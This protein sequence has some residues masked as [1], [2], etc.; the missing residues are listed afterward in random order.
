MD[1]I[2]KHQTSLNRF[3]EFLPDHM[4][5]SE[6]NV[7]GFLY[8]KMRSNYIML[9]TWVCLTHMDLYRFALPDFNTGQISDFQRA[10]PYEFLVRCQSQVVAYACSLA[11]FWMYAGEMIGTR[12]RSS[13]S[14]G[15]LTIDW[16][17]GAGAVDVVTVLLTAR[18]YPSLYRK[19]RDGS[20][21]QLCKAKDV[22]DDMLSSMISSMIS[23]LDMVKPLVPRIESY[24]RVTTLLL[25]CCLSLLTCPI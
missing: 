12:A 14:K 25:A 15:L 11:Q 21:A 20:S 23:V 8:D 1:I 13:I 4:K 6:Q 2:N 16:M 3:N 10:I 5:L 22:D 17:I 7:E 24:V 18:K 19:L 9:H